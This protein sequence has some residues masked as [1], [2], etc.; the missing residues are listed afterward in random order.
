MIN[1][2]E[3]VSDT[4]IRELMDKAQSRRPR[5]PTKTSTLIITGVQR[6]RDIYSDDS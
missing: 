4:A 5:T 1:G 6:V 2:V 3:S